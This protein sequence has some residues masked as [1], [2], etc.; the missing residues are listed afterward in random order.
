MA[1]E[2][3][4][5]GPGQAHRLF[6]A[7]WP[8]AALQAVLV[9]RL[10]TLAAAVRGR[11]QR[12]DQWHLTLEFLGGVPADRVPAVEQAAAAVEGR[13]FEICFDQVEYWRRA[14][15]LCLAAS[16]VPASLTDLVLELRSALAA[17]GFEPERREFRPHLTLARKVLRAPRKRPI[18]PLMWPASEFVLVE[19]A[20]GP[21]GSR[22]TVR[23]RWPL[24]G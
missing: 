3:G 16:T 10:P 4:Q 12:P 9:E 24:V 22:Y 17:R 7:L 19:S 14:Q 18:G 6:F 21:D 23:R 11:P 20:T 15:V 1:R 13:C 8:D 5:P 2:R